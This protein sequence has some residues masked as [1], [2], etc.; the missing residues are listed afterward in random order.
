M[1]SSVLKR[2]TVIAGHRTSVSLEDT[3]PQMS[4]QLELP[5]M[6]RGEAPREKR[7]EEVSSA[8]HEG[9]RSGTSDLMERV[10]ERT[11]LQAALKRVRKNKGSAG[12]DAINPGLSETVSYNLPKG[13]YAE[14]C[15]FPDPRTGEPHAFMGM[16]RIVTLA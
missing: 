13:T 3:R 12:I 7:S 15:F 1:K 8:N 5:L 4:R 16:V 10:C 6:G 14:L 2:S 9:E 11:N